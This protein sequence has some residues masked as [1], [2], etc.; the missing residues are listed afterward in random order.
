MWDLI[1][2][3]LAVATDLREWVSHRRR[4]LGYLRD[5]LGDGYSTGWLPPSV[6]FG[7]M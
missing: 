6:P 1:A 2:L 4:A 7:S 5:L 3:V